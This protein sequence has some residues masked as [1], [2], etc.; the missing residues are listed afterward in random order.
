VEDIFSKIV[1]EYFPTILGRKEMPTKV[2]E[3]CR[4]P[5]TLGQKGN[6]LWHIILKTLNIQNKKAY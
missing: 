5:N 3:T 1:E 4:T 2:Q 6:S